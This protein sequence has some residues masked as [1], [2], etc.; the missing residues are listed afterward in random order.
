MDLPNDAR[1]MRRDRVLLA[2]LFGELEELLAWTVDYRGRL[3]PDDIADRVAPAWMVV[4]PN[5]ALVRGALLAPYEGDATHR[6]SSSEGTESSPPQGDRIT[7]AHLRAYGLTGDLL[8]LRVE[9]F[10]AEKRAFYDRHRKYV[11][12]GGRLTRAW[13]LLRRRAQSANRAGT[14]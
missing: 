1:G 3:L 4:R 13:R 14:S 11:E 8:K 5:F 12:E 9:T 6:G 7:D 10:Q 2:N